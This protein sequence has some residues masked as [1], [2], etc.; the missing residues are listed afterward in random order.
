MYPPKIVNAPDV[1]HCSLQLRRPFKLLFCAGIID[2]SVNTCYTFA[3]VQSAQR[4][5]FPSVCLWKRVFG[6]QFASLSLQGRAKSFERSD[7][8]VYGFNLELRTI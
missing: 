3:L 8:L 6:H 7:L 1:L 2:G 4:D 5:F